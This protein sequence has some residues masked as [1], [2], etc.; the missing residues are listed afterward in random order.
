MTTSEARIQAN[1]RNAAKS[2]GP[3]TEEGKARSRRNGLKHGMTG[4]GIVLAET[5]EAEI[6]RRTEALQDELAPESTLGTILVRQIARLSVRMERSNQQEIASLAR[7]VRHAVDDFD[8]ERIDEAQWLFDHLGEEPRGHLRKLRKSPEGIER[9]VEAW[10]DLRADLTREPRPTWTERHRERAE[11]LT[12]YRIEEAS[13]SSLFTLSKATW[14]D[15]S[16]L[17]EGGEPDAEKRKAWARARLVERIEAEI[18]SLEQDCMAID[19]KTI[20]IDR[21]EAPDRA[22]FDPSKEASLARRYEAEATR[23]FYKALNQLRQVEAEAAERRELD[24]ISISEETYDP[25]ASSRE[26]RVGMVREPQPADG[27]A[28][29]S[30]ESAAANHG[31]RLNNES[32]SPNSLR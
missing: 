27:F 24:Q 14:G 16:G 26:S 25:L 28:R 22:L 4:E 1:R 15:F 7:R 29:P 10:C 13:G 5:D 9:L 8:Q 31:S 23:G 2:T 32:F 17:K 20:E 21:A 30:S 6:E 3:K 12:G 11:N 19:F 18:A